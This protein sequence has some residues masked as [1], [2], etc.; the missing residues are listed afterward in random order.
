L[1][2]SDQRGKN[3]DELTQLVVDKTG[4]PE[5]K[6]RMAVDTVLGYLKDRLPEPVAGQIDGV[7]SGESGLE[8]QAGGLLKGMGGLLG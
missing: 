6:A 3:M 4:L 7:L 8:D 5:D 2:Y 1:D